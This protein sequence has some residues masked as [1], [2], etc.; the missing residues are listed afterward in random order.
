MAETRSP[1]NICT[2]HI[3]RRIFVLRYA[4]G[5]YIIVSFGAL[6]YYRK[7]FSNYTFYLNMEPF[8]VGAAAISLC[9]L[10]IQTAYQL[11][12]VAK[13][14]RFARR[15]LGDLTAEMDLFSHF[16]NDFMK[17]TSERKKR[18]GRASSARKRLI[19]WAERA[20]LDFQKLSQRVDALARDPV[21]EHSF[22]DVVSAHVKWFL[23]MDNWKYLRYTLVVARQSMVGFTY[24]CNMER[25]DEQLAFLRSI[26]TAEQRN[27]IEQEYGETVEKLIN[28]LECEM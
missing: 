13:S 22:A 26:I 10:I 9:P 5:L 15:E 4:S 11:R 27:K 24:V 16:Y 7:A 21:H 8:S 28:N 14:I 23:D 18:G 12:R 3:P 25:L 19:S 17:V 1:V 20:K 2:W 6:E